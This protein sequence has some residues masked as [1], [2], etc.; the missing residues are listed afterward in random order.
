MTR[1]VN[2]SSTHNLA[3]LPKG[4]KGSILGWGAESIA[5]GRALSCGFLVFLSL[6]RDSK[7][8]AV[9]DSSGC[10]FRLSIKSTSTG[11]G[12]TASSGWRSGQQIS[13]QATSRQKPLSADESD[14]LIG[15]DNRYG[16]C[17]IVPI[18]YCEIFGKT[19]LEDHHLLEFEEKWGVFAMPPKGL[20]K[21]DLA[22]GFRQKPLVELKKIASSLGV[23]PP[24]SYDFNFSP[25]NV[26]SRSTKTLK[27]EDWYVV[28]IW[29]AIF[30][31]L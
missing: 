19:K 16:L 29:R 13:R 20:T 24:S 1:L 17:W 2:W 30:A 22:K 7:Y 21:E 4:N 27:P 11:G 23:M 15:V 12:I 31:T 5:L 28:S 10:M 8:D 18:E 25:S 9:L 3:G 6:W 14:F 26:R